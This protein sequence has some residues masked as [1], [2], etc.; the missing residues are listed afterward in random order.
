MD[1]VAGSVIN[2]FKVGGLESLSDHC[3]ISL[4]LCTP[5]THRL[6]PTAPNEL[7]G[8]LANDLMNRVDDPTENITVNYKI[9]WNSDKLQDLNDYLQQHH[10]RRSNISDNSL[11]MEILIE[12]FTINL[13]MLE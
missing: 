13:L 3:P 10:P 6:E 7:A 11:S 12:N 2:S 9:H 4:T 8:A 1:Q 5:N